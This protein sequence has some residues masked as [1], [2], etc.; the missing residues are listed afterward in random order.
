[1]ANLVLICHTEGCVNEGVEITLET[2]SPNVACGPCGETI[3]D[4]TEVTE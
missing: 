1:M 4:K 3:T 2:E